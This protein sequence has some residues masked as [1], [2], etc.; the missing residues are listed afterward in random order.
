[1]TLSSRFITLDR[2]NFIKVSHHYLTSGWYQVCLYPMPCELIN[3]MYWVKCKQTQVWQPYVHAFFCVDGNQAMTK[4]AHWYSSSYD[5]EKILRKASQR[6]TILHFFHINK[7]VWKMVITNDLEWPILS[8]NVIYYEKFRKV[9]KRTAR[10]Q[11]LIVG[12]Y[13]L[14]CLAFLQRPHELNLWDTIIQS[15]MYMSIG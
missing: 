2:N 12:F 13:E 3:G 11:R 14:I 6:P 5:F 10:E 7:G 9:M 8:C 4:F 1:M 15:W